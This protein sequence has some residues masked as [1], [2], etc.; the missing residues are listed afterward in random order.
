MT[1]SVVL[2]GLCRRPDLFQATLASLSDLA[3]GGLA[4][5]LVI[6]TWADET[7]AFENNLNGLATA[8]PVTLVPCEKPLLE[9]RIPGSVLHQQTT[10]RGA[11]DAARHELVFRIRSDLTFTPGYLAGLVE[12]YLALRST[13]SL[14]AD[15]RDIIVAPWADIEEPFHIADECFLT[16][17]RTALGLR[18]SDIEGLARYGFPMANVHTLFFGPPYWRR[19]PIFDEFLLAQ[20]RSG[21]RFNRTGPVKWE[22]LAKALRFPIYRDMI[23]LYWEI[24]RADFRLRLGAD[25]LRFFPGGGDA[26]AAW[27]RQ[28]PVRPATVDEAFTSR[29]G[30]FGNHIYAYALDQLPQAAGGDPARAQARPPAQSR[31]EFGELMQALA[32]CAA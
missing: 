13:R 21:C 23:A 20:R 12:D 18:T 16:T 30:G 32:L 19:F 9:L 2:T 27:Y 24:L 4:L 26:L 25:E 22:L 3:R 31:A 10:F 14:F 6:A 17:R 7:A 15:E 11:V 29:F 1:L 8:Y 28:P 5:E